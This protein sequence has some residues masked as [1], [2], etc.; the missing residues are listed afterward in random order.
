LPNNF[1]NLVAGERASKRGVVAKKAEKRNGGDINRWCSR[2]KSKTGEE[3]HLNK[4][5]RRHHSAGGGGDGGKKRGTSGGA[6]KPPIKRETER[7][8][9]TFRETEGE[10]APDLFRGKSR[11]ERKKGMRI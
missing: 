2:E 1:L 7:G 10:N 6:R 8:V 4:R 11:K 3:F 5:G 9:P